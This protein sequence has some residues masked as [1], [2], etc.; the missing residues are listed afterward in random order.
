MKVDI[1]FTEN[2]HVVLII[3]RRKK[4]KLVILSHFDLILYAIV[5][6]T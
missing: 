4:L 3:T 2:I 6:N 5:K 1:N